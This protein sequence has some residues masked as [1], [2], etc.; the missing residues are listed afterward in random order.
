MPSVGNRERMHAQ[1]DRER[2]RLQISHKLKP[3]SIIKFHLRKRHAGRQEIIQSEVSP[4]YN[5]FTSVF[6]WL[7]MLIGVQVP[8]CLSIPQT[9]LVSIFC[10]VS[11]FSMSFSQ[12]RC[13]N[14]IQGTASILWSVFET[15]KYQIPVVLHSHSWMQG[16]FW[17]SPW[18]CS[19]C[20][21]GAA[22]EILQLA[23]LDSYN[24]I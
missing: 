12:C 2:N 14:W 20:G 1:E 4:C 22:Q 18:F 3:D 17:F 24:F 16:S 6:F 21:N 10:L 19:S 23:C 7:A 9:I 11:N 8:H 13:D 15:E 5:Q